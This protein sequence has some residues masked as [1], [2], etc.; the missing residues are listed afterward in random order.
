MIKNAWIQTYTGRQVNVFSPKYEDINIID[1]AHSLS[2]QCRFTGHVKKFY[3]VAEHSYHISTLVS[4]E[5]ALHGLLHDA[6]E[7]Y[8][9]DIPR[10]I[11]PYLNNYVSIENDLLDIIFDKFGISGKTPK[12]VKELDRRLCLTEGYYLMPDIS[13]WLSLKDYQP[14]THMNLKC[15]TPGEAKQQFLY[16]Y[17][18]LTNGTISKESQGNK[19]TEQSRTV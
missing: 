10:P 13:D 8:L 5:F 2:N 15:W 18:E 14:I 19:G 3:S 4:K 9:T 17:L 1:I 11:K 6:S 12:E 7:A 16:R